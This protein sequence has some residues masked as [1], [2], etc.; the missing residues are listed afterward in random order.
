MYCFKSD[1]L[2]ILLIVVIISL[3]FG[4]ILFHQFT[5]DDHKGIENNRYIESLRNF[6]YLF[7]KKYFSAFG[8]RSYRPVVTAS[9]FFDHQLW[10]KRAFG[11]HL[12]NLLLHI[13]TVVFF[14]IFLRYFFEDR[15]V[16][17]FAALFF[18]LHPVVCE[19]VNSLSF[20]EDLLTGLFVMTT[21]VLILSSRDRSPLHLIAGVFTGLFA[22]FSKESAIPLFFICLLLFSLR[23]GQKNG[24]KKIL[25]VPALTLQFLILV[26]YILI[27]FGI[28]VPKDVWQTRLLGGDAAAASAHSGF[29][30]FKVWQTLVWPFHLNAD[31]VFRDI[32]GIIT[33]YS[34][35]GML[36]LFLY[37]FLL[38]LIY[39]RGYKRLFA[40]L[41]WILLFFIPSSNLIP[42]TNPFAERYL[43]LILPGFSILTALGFEYIQK[44]MKGKYVKQQNILY[45]FPILLLIFIAALSVNRNLVW[46]T[47]KT[48][49]S[50]TL[51]R[52]PG[53]VRALN[54]VGLV[55]IQKGEFDKAEKLFHNALSIDPR[56][57]E[58]RNNLAVVYIHTQK[59]DRAKEELEKA[60]RIK[61]DYA[62]AH[63]N[64]ARLY[65]YE[66]EKGL[67]K[68]RIHLKRALE[69]GYPVPDSFKDH[70][71]F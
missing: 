21:L 60:L 4:N 47:D 43:Y 55:F 25:S 27:R 3:I 65:F 44:K 7:S 58:L 57:Y 22:L 31:Y 11:Y 63:Y 62:A 13:L 40:G 45:I 5:Y 23:I 38:F 12:T 53:S 52:E 20:R 48:L 64:L 9:Y 26:I 24:S 15:N 67:E 33:P 36:F 35:M 42:L 19:P 46:S 59:P 8:E 2:P 71:F 54:G 16:R 6:P 1:I 70:I 18:A 61:P 29:L 39:K 41:C 37:F 66:G 28:M 17:L 51:E 14:Y 34:I 56:D 10:G 30:F 49:W 32:R 50:A 69:L 68:A